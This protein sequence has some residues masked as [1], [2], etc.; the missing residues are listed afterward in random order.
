VPTADLVIG[1][2]APP[3]ATF[4]PSF[5]FRVAEVVAVHRTGGKPIS[6]AEVATLEAYLKKE[7]K[8]P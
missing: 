5:T 7:Y 3:G 4:N 2:V 1:S 6:D 8:T